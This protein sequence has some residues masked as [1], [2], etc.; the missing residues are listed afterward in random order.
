M[1][2][3]LEEK[4]CQ[5]IYKW[6]FM[7]KYYY[8][9]RNENVV[10]IR[11]LTSKLLLWCKFTKSAKSTF[12]RKM[13]SNWHKNVSHHIACL[14]KDW[15]KTSICIKRRIV[16]RHI[17]TK[18]DPTILHAKTKSELSLQE[19][20]INGWWKSLTKICWKFRLKKTVFN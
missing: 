9:F 4:T 5:K 3:R 14:N 19:S 15:I 7:A 16:A 11:L 1:C 6:R 20:A 18:L 2:K 17:D 8:F 13:T 12:N 10:Q